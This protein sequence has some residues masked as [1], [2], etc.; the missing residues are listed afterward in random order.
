LLAEQDIDAAEAFRDRRHQRAL[1]RH[2]MLLDQA[3]RLVGERVVEF[4]DP[5]LAGIGWKE[6]DPDPGRDNDLLHFGANLGADAIAFDEGHGIRLGHAEVLERSSDR[7][8]EIV[9]T[10]R[11]LMPIWSQ[12]EEEAAAAGHGRRVPRRAWGSS[13]RPSA[14]RT[15]SRQSAA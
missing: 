4:F 7:V 15:T 9:A 10:A 5:G 1:D 6:L 11:A 8:N 12:S 2:A 3:Q 14:R 13:P